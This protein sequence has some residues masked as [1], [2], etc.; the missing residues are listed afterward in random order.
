MIYIYKHTTPSGRCYI[1][2]TVNTKNRWQPMEYYD[3]PKF[4]KAIVQYGWLNITHEIIHECETQEE[5][6]EMER[7]YIA[8][9]NSIENGYN[10]RIGGTDIKGQN[11]PF[12]GR[13][14]TEESKEKIRKNRTKHIHTPEEIENLRERMTGEGNPMYGVDVKT[15]MTEE[16]IAEWK[17]HLSQARSGKNNPAAN[18]VVLIDTLT[19]ERK[20]LEYRKLLKDEI[21]MAG[22][23]APKYIKSGKLYKN[24][25]KL[26]EVA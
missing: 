20:I 18:P 9:Y 13:K 19:G 8:K 3:C 14:H 26:E 21:G 1:G 22:C 6:D 15:R 11:N 12:Y 7:F 10:I 4:F 25:Y 17:R 16:K 23:H 24:R 5:A 2:Q